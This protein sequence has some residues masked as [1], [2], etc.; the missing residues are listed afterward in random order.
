MSRYRI[1]TNGRRWRVQQKGWFF[2]RDTHP[3]RVYG[4]FEAARNEKL[5]LQDDDVSRSNCT[6]G[7]WREVTQDDG[8]ATDP[9]DLF[10]PGYL[11]LPHPPSPD[12]DL[13]R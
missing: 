9:V 3:F 6:Q 2:W 11:P 5:N 13:G 12:E 8:V 7:P 10:Y 1:V 4:T